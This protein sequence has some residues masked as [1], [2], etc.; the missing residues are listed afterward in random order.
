MLC[1][2]LSTRYNYNDVAMVGQVSACCYTLC[3]FSFILPQKDWE[4][5]DIYNGI[6]AVLGGFIAILFS[7]VP[8][9]G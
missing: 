6:F 2:L 7:F 5:S 9:S 1:K 8:A 3:K 4:S